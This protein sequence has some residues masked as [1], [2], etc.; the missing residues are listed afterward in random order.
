MARK[1]NK[2]RLR[3]V[4][5]GTLSVLAIGFFFF[6][7][8]SYTIDIKNLKQESNRLSRELL[9]LKESEENLKLEITKL[10][11]L[12]Y[13]ARYAREN[14][15]YSK[16]GEY[17]INIKETAKNVES[18]EE[19]SNLIYY[20]IGGTAGLFLIFLYVISKGSKSKKKS[21]RK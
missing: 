7:L 1:T 15:L 21:N 4:V 16:D 13:V 11:D 18:N 12:E 17:I 6:S 5:F 10:K 3:L 20:I 8:I 19:D 2:R 14:Y 9:E